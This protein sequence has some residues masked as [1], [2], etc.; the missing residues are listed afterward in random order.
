MFFRQQSLALT[1][2]QASVL[3]TLV[4]SLKCVNLSGQ[5]PASD[6][7]IMVKAQI[8]TLHLIWKNDNFIRDF[9]PLPPMK[10]L[11]LCVHACI[12]EKGD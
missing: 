7:I 9:G 6:K 4:L 5:H 11:A 2:C 10:P 12:K 8:D 1:T 3:C